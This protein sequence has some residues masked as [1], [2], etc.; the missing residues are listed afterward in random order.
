MCHILC[1]SRSSYLLALEQYPSVRMAKELQNS[2]RI[3]GE[4]FRI[5]LERTIARKRIW[6]RYQEIL[7]N[8]L[9]NA[10]P[11]DILRKCFQQ[12]HRIANELIEIRKRQEFIDAR[13]ADVMNEWVQKTVEGRKRVQRHRR[14]RECIKFNIE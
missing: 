3:A 6:Q 13:R 11:E 2:Q 7:M 14:L 4:E 8:E 10:C 1:I 9:K 12:W 5:M